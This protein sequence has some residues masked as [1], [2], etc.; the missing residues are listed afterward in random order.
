MISQSAVLGSQDLHV[1]TTMSDGDLPIE[2]VVALA[3]SLGVRVGIADHVSSRNRRLFV[4]DRERLKRYLAAT[5]AVDAFRSAELCWTNPFSM[6]VAGELAEQLDYLVGSNHG[7][8]LA[9]GVEIS[10]WTAE[11][12]RGWEV[13]SGE[14]MDRIVDN[15]CELVRTMPI[16]IVA[17][18]TLLP[19]AL[20]KLEPAEAWWSEAR[21]E[22]F[23]EAV[24]ESG[25]AMEISN[26]YQLPHD[27]LLV[28]ARE[29]GAHFSLG[30]DGHHRSQV[31][32]LGWAVD[33]ARRVGVND[34]CLFSPEAAR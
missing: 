6:D 26:R 32:Q 5:A 13:H 12:P 20:L 7:F 29:A 21:E 22:R 24:V 30:S 19:P 16:A 1:H 33:T 27:R 25:V 18:S 9:E 23:V 15:L 31:A 28:R 14:I 4:A 11:L 2:E 3:A 34:N 8:A 17:H 10:P